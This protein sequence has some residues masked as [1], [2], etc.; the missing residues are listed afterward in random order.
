MK[1]T[2]LFFSGPFAVTALAARKN[3]N[4]VLIYTD[5]IGYGDFSCYGATRVQT[6]NVD[7]LANNGVR[8]RNAHS[9]ATT[10]TLSR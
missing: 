4:I 10:S 8:F 7:A 3:F 2:I 1:K 5:D 9:A 6:S